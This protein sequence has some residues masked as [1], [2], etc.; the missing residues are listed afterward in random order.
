[1]TSLEITE[2]ESREVELTL[3]NLEQNLR[4]EFW[5]IYKSGK[6]EDLKIDEWNAFDAK[7]AK[8]YKKYLDSRKDCA[9][10][11]I[12]AS[13]LSSGIFEIKA[14]EASAAKKWSFSFFVVLEGSFN[15]LK[16]ASAKFVNGL[17]IDGGDCDDSRFKSGDTFFNDVEIRKN[18]FIGGGEFFGSFQLRGINLVQCLCRFIKV[19]F[20]KDFYF[21]AADKVRFEKDFYFYASGEAK[22]TKLAIDEISRGKISGCVEI[23]ESIF[24][25]EAVFLFMG[26]QADFSVNFFGDQFK[27]CFGFRI[28][29][30]DSSIKSLSILETVFYDVSM[31]DQ[32]EYLN[33]ENTSRIGS[34]ELELSIFRDVLVFNFFN[35][36]AV[37]DFSEAGFIDNK[38]L[39]FRE[40]W[41][42]NED[43]IGADLERIFRNDEPKFRFLKKYFAEQGNHFKE[44]EYFSYE[45][46]AAEKRRLRKLQFSNPKTKIFAKDLRV[47]GLTIFKWAQDYLEL[48]LFKIYKWTSGY[49]ASIFLPSFWLLASCAIVNL[50]FLVPLGS[51]LELTIAPISRSESVKEIFKDT[52]PVLTVLSLINVALIFLFGLG[53]RNKFKIK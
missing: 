37:P 45:M 42:I 26:T 33:K 50:S 2:K 25:N 39:S 14:S 22:N 6:S 53:L 43:A 12:S 44:R 28:G 36:D 16:L 19:R 40:S 49:G 10:L 29:S 18:F 8:L 46:R 47:I 52:E 11:I 31:F 48:I 1:M 9:Q 23:T 32:D 41:K 34:I 17:Q 38:K 7:M 13:E 35:I 21:Y 20:A 27:G 3:E 15:K 5:K 51:A 4:N 24:D 30:C